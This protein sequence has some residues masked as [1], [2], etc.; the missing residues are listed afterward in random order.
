MP[1]NELDLRREFEPLPSDRLRALLDAETEKAVPDDDIVL[2]ILHILEDRE[3][4]ELLPASPKEEAAWKLY[5][6]RVRARKWKQPRR[7]T[8]LANAA[9]LLLVMGLLFTVVPQEAG[10]ESLWDVL[11]RWTHNAV[12]FFNPIEIKDKSPFVFETDNPAM[13]QIYDEAV[14][15][16]IEQPLIPTWFPEEYVLDG[17]ATVNISKEKCL[18]AR[19]IGESEEAVLQI[20]VFEKDILHGYFGEKE[21]H[22]QFEREGAEYKTMHNNDRWTA[23]WIIDNKIEYSVAMDCQEETLLRILDSIYVTEG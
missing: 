3:P 9:A 17:I 12:E 4:E 21:W 14:K 15:M 23:V 2:A 10:A 16:G 1:K 11:V 20:K 6:K 19:F 18:A 8:G 7:W 13:Q 5:R 22:Q